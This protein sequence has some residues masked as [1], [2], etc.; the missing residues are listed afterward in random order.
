LLDELYDWHLEILTKTA[1]AVPPQKFFI[2]AIYNDSAA[3]FTKDF[4][5]HPARKISN[6]D[7]AAYAPSTSLRT[8]FGC[9]S[10]PA[11]LATSL[12]DVAA[13]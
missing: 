6:N 4:S 11:T 8:G 7:A 3:I 1:H 9:P 12:C 10:R 13:Q 2:M 5:G